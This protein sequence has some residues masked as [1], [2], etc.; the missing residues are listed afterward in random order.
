MV[1]TD[2]P[3]IEQVNSIVRGDEDFWDD[4]AE[5][6]EEAKQNLGS[7][8]DEFNRRVEALQK[9]KMTVRSWERALRCN[10]CQD[11]AVLR[12]KRESDGK[13]YLR[14]SDDKHL[15]QWI[16]VDFK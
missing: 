14:L 13:I 15:G 3:W 2:E 5:S 8:K 16:E 7:Y 9:P 11:P 1:S 12:V 4:P 10:R 6:I